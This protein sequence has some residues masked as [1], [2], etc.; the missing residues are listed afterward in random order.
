MR[1][2]LTFVEGHR[3]GL[4][5]LADLVPDDNEHS[6]LRAGQVASDGKIADIQRDVSIASLVARDV[7]CAC[8]AFHTVLDVFRA[9]TLDLQG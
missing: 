1:I 6:V 3:D 9:V 7:V 8:L 2:L 5:H 4:H